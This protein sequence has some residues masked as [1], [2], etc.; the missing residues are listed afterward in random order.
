MPTFHH[1]FNSQ[2]DLIA[3]LQICHDAGIDPAFDADMDELEH[4][5]AELRLHSI[6]E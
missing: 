5:F 6:S 3:A 4:Q 1:S 2:A